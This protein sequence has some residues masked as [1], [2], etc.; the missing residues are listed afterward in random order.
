MIRS[1][2]A[3][4]SMNL[5]WL[6]HHVGLARPKSNALDYDLE[7]FGS[8]SQNTSSR[9]VAKTRAIF[10]ASIVD[11]THLPF[12]ILFIVTLVTLT[13]SANSS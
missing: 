12:S 1:A 3:G 10:K 5:W 9:G 4:M 8:A 6:E 2:A 7:Q 13:L 11:G